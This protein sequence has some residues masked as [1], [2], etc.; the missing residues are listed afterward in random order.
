MTKVTKEA[1][2]LT[3]EGTPEEINETLEKTTKALKAGGG[4]VTDVEYEDGK[5]FKKLKDLIGQEGAK[6]FFRKNEAD[7]RIS[8]AECTLKVADAVSQKEANENYARAKQIVK[9]FDKST[10]EA[11]AAARLMLKVATKSINR[12]KD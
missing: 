8:I 2:T 5:D 11:T 12:R 10:N 7:L 4:E 6:A 3:L 9:D 1:N